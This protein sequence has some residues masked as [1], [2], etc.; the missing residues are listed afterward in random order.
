MQTA[1][2]RA[3]TSALVQREDLQ[4][5]G[6]EPVSKS[7]FPVE[8]R[9]AFVLPSYNLRALKRESCLTEFPLR[10]H[11]QNRCVKMLY[12]CQSPT[13]RRRYN[14]KCHMTVSGPKSVRLSSSV[15]LTS[16]RLIASRLYRLLYTWHSGPR[17][18]C[19]HSNM[20]QALD[21][22]FIFFWTVLALSDDSVF[23]VCRQTWYGICRTGRTA[24]SG[25]GH[26][27]ATLDQCVLV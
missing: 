3:E 2:M 23:F 15:R 10:E 27:I 4:S 9:T 26:L 7:L 25:H 5:R 1:W 13:H 18:A 8:F 12:K 20:H 6:Q 21:S 24:A 14:A 19:M 11:S 22:T 17:I 16:V